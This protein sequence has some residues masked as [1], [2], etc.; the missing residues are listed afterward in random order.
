MQ[1]GEIIA[2]LFAAVLLI[3]VV[4]LVFFAGGRPLWPDREAKMVILLP[5]DAMR[6]GS[7]RALAHVRLPDAFDTRMVQRRPNPDSRW[8]S[9]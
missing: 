5:P 2:N 8:A 4:A 1:L 9:P 7:V 3:C 6:T